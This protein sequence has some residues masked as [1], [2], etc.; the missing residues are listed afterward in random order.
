MRLISALHLTL[1]TSRDSLVRLLISAMHREF[2]I[3]QL[4]AYTRLNVLSMLRYGNSIVHCYPVLE[5]CAYFDHHY[6]QQ[7]CTRRQPYSVGDSGGRGESAVQH[8]QSTC[9][10]LYYDIRWICIHSF[11]MCRTLVVC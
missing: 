6:G 7:S 5:A 10:V 2:A 9:I 1:D 11:R 8:C 3:G 4:S